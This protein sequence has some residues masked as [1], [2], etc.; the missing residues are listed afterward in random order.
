MSYHEHESARSL[1]DHGRKNEFKEFLCHPK[2][3]ILVYI[4]SNKF[5][6]LHSYDVDYEEL[7]EVLLNSREKVSD[8]CNSTKET[9]D[10]LRN[11]MDSA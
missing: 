10:K 11:I 7:F 9:V 1:S 8:G 4:L 3:G 5:V 2:H 6:A